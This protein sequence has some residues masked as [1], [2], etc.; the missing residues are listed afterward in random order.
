MKDIHLYEQI[1]GLEKPWQVTGVELKHKEK[2]LEVRVDCGEQVWGCPECERRMHVHGREERRWRHLDTCQYKTMIVCEVP[3]VK[4]E[5][6]G[7]QTVQVPWAEKYSRFTRWFE[8]F[9][10]DVMKECSGK[11]ACG[12]LGITW[13]EADHIKEKAVKRGLERKGKKV[14]EVVCMDE[15]AAGH[16]HD[17]VTV[18]AKVEAG[19][20]VV[21]GVMDGRKQEA[22]D[23][24]WRQFSAEGLERV[25]AIGMDMWEPYWKSAMAHVPGA[26]RKIVYDRFHLMQHLNRAVDD[27]RKDEHLM[28]AAKGNT[29]LKGTKPL[30]LYGLENLPGN[31]DA[32]LK[33]CL[34]ANLKTA[35]AW[36]IKELFRHLYDCATVA[37]AADFFRVW[38][39]CAMRTA[40]APIKKV[41][42]LFRACRD[43]ILTWFEHRV[44]NSF[45]E[46]LNNLIQSVIKK[47][48]GYRNRERLKRDILFHAGGL[49]LYPITQTQ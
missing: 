5:E 1:L 29:A 3:R 26:A 13:D 7:A 20:A 47:A 33:A 10:I 49:E 38:Y 43:N 44:S 19:K 35:R 30:W 37:E 8:R 18:A 21:D 48:Y 34:R 41:A 11:A 2:E 27:V 36:R 14:P 6:H 23:Q 25:K 45:S 9:G 22:A 46:G 31:W 28:L 17:Y 12:L 42:S 16:G 24:Y 15:K 4:C 39:R 32:Q 40:L